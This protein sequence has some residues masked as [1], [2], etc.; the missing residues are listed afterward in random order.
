MADIVYSSMKRDNTINP[1]SHR[2]FTRADCMEWLDKLED[3]SVNCWICYDE[4]TE[5]MTDSGW[6]FFKD[7]NIKTDKFLSMNP[8]TRDLEYISAIHK[9]DKAYSGK[10]YDFET[11]KVHITVTPEHKLITEHQW[12]PGLHFEKAEDIFHKGNR[13]F[14]KNGG[15]WKGEDTGITPDFAYLLGI[16]I[17]DGACVI[18]HPDY[19]DSKN[20]ILTQKKASIRE[21]IKEKLRICKINYTERKDGFYIC[22]PDYKKFEP[23]CK[24]SERRVPNCIKYAAQDMILAFLEGVIDGDGYN[25]KELKNGLFGSRRIEMGNLKLL[26]DI[27]E[28]LYKVN[29]SGRIVERERIGKKALLKSENR[30]IEIKKPTYIL[31]ISNEKNGKVS[32]T[33]QQFK[34]ENWIDYTGHVYCVSLPKWHTVLVKKGFTCP[35]WQAQCD[36]PYNVL[37]GNMKNKNGAAIF[38]SRYTAQVSPSESDL[39]KGMVTPRFEVAIP[40]EEKSK[41]EDYKNYCYT[42]YC[43]AH[44]KLA[45][46]SFM[47]IFWSMKYLY[48][49]YQLFDVNR[50]IFWQQPN[51][52]SSITGDFSYDITPIIVIRK[53]NARLNKKAKLWDKTSVLKFAK[54][55]GNYRDDKLSHPCQ[56]PRKLLEHLVWLSDADQPGNVIGDFFAGSGSL[57]RAVNQ[58]DVILCDKNREYYDKFF[59]TYVTDPRV[60]KCK[61]EDFIKKR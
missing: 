28:L 17:A 38:H 60:Y 8:E 32:K 58:A 2:K 42:W 6:K 37:T 14:Q 13:Y 55:Q 43:K 44:Q 50:I 54:P 26:E 33:N 5:V 48:L 51:M 7:V 56:K 21:K 19:S 3:E 9:I 23:L 35:T 53:G 18:T 57:L 47:F 16:Y 40:W 49:A 20:V 45:D 4:Q 41:L 12:E 15:N 59:D 30:Y 27:Q 52:I 36:P 61:V 46:D 24:K 11:D 34:N 1:N 39:K 10:M 25:T 29:C 22:A 31:S